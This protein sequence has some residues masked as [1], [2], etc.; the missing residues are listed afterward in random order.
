MIRGPGVFDIGCVQG[1]LL[2]AKDLSGQ[3]VEVPGR[4]VKELLPLAERARVGTSVR[5]QNE[6]PRHR[7]GARREQ[8]ERV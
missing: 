4:N 2:F 3:V 8:L 5:P 1:L 6:A 7:C